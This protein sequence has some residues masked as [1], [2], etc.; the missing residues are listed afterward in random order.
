MLQT[1]YLQEN[2]ELIDSKGWALIELPL[3]F[4]QKLLIGAQN[5]FHANEFTPAGITQSEFIP[6]EAAI[7]IRS[8][9]TCWLNLE[10]L[11]EDENSLVHFLNIIKD[12]LSDF[13]R[14]R[15]THFECHYAI[16]QPGQSYKKHTDQTKN[17]NHRF[18]SFVI[19]LNENW[20]K[21]D[22]GTLLGYTNEKTIFE[23]LP[24]LGKMIIFRSDIEHEVIQSHK[25]RW[26]LTGWFRT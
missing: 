18:F 22:G 23:V 1:N 10:K 13:F 14:I 19:Y 9:L 3:D 16:Y 21:K 5:R 17:N 8:D 15:L 25:S 2:F 24:L 26:S 20:Q 11:T 6:L 4:C 12:N 7:A